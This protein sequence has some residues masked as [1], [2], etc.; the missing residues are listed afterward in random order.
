MRNPTHL[1]FVLLT[2]TCSCATPQPQRA[3]PNERV[4]TALVRAMNDYHGYPD[5]PHRVIESSATGVVKTDWFPAHKGEVELKIVGI[6]DGERYTVEAW[7]R[8]SFFFCRGRSKTRLSRG[9]ESNIVK[10]VQHLLKE[11]KGN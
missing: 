10:R 1:L 9:A 11:E 5:Y 6:V 3:P 8:S 4:Y 7:Q 2:L